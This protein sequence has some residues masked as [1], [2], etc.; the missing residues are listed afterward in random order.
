MKLN[1]RVCASVCTQIILSFWKRYKNEEYETPEKKHK[2][3]SNHTSNPEI[4]LE[5]EENAN[6]MCLFWTCMH[7][8]VSF[9]LFLFCFS[10]LFFLISLVPNSK[11]T[12]LLLYTHVQNTSNIQKWAL[13]H[14]CPIN[15]PNGYIIICLCAC[16]KMHI[17]QIFGSSLNQRFSFCQHSCAFLCGV[18]VCVWHRWRGEIEN[19]QIVL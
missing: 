14:F 15:A 19:I 18:S 1:V 3:S 13:S 7:Y 10:A 11:C 5:K 2:S 12:H 8:F 9:Y 4:T 6:H 17:S 16:C